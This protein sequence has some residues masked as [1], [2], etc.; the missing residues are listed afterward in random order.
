MTRIENKGHLK[1]NRRKGLGSRSKVATN[2][3]TYKCKSKDGEG[4]E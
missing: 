2:D 1:R 4:S 3:K